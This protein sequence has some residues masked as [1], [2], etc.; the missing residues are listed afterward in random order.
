MHS[1]VLLR[2]WISLLRGV[3]SIMALQFALLTR[4]CGSLGS[5]VRLESA[6]ESEVFYMRLTYCPG[7][8]RLACEKLSSL[9]GRLAF[10]VLLEECWFYYAPLPYC[11]RYVADSLQVGG[12]TLA[13]CSHN[14]ALLA[15]TVLPVDATL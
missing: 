3:F 10:L 15:F 7:F 11:L 13:G 5:G 6:P 14:L 2:E 1:N 9:C 8:F 12:M 4:W